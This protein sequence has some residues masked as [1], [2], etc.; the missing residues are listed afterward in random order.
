MFG[1]V[2]KELGELVKK[3]AETKIERND[4][5]PHTTAWH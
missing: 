5:H 3:S 1:K 2:D 4:E